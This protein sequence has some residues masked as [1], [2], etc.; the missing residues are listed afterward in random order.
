MGTE[1]HWP[2][3]PFEVADRPCTVFQLLRNYLLLL[4]SNWTVSLLQETKASSGG[5][6]SVW[7]YVIWKL[8]NSW[9][10][11]KKPTKK[12]K[13][14][15]W[16]NMT[17]RRDQHIYC[18]CILIHTLI[19]Q[20]YSKQILKTLQNMLRSSRIKLCIIIIIPTTYLELAIYNGECRIHSNINLLFNYH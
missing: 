15:R 17:L 8:F 19:T 6:E 7:C 18:K 3:T 16:R 20:A 12:K 10:K 14:S 11:K 1:E 9:R 2:T 5:A 4:W 13:L